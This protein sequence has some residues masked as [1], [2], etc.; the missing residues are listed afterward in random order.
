MGIEMTGDAGRK[1]LVAAL[2]KVHLQ[3]FADVAQADEQDGDEADDL[4][5]EERDYPVEFVVEDDPEEE[6][7]EKQVGDPV[8]DRL[9]QLAGQVQQAQQGGDQGRL[10]EVLGE[11]GSTL[12]EMRGDSR[13]KE[14]PAAPS[15]DRDALIKKYDEE[16]FYKNPAAAVI[17]ILEQ[18][19]QGQIAPAYGQL[20]QQMQSILPQVGKMQLSQ[21]EDY[22]LV[23]DQWGDEVDQEVDRLNQRLGAN[24]QHLQEA[25]ERVSGRHMREIFEQRQQAA[26]QQAEA[27]QQAPRQRRRTGVN[28]VSRAGSP[29]PGEGG[30]R[31]VSIT[32][33]E[34]AKVRAWAS[35]KPISEESALEYWLANGRKLP[36]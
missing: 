25:L 30:S 7:E 6:Q 15:F 8:R 26:Q 33:S 35:T 23:L 28:P 27:G 13:K 32:R 14:E 17:D 3:W 24:Q 12:K 31:Q 18:Y 21:N 9:E 5:V 29:P 34:M 36:Q 20:Y 22:R 2:D 1:G 10:A 19:T 16:A 11:L 4:A